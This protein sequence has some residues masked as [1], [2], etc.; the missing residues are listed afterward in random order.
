MGPLCGVK[1]LAVVDEM[2]VVATCS[3]ACGTFLV[4]N[5]GIVNFLESASFY[6][7]GDLDTIDEQ[8]RR[9]IIKTVEEM[10]MAEFLKVLSL[11]G[12]RTNENSP[13]LRVVQSELPAQL[14]FLRVRPVFDI[15]ST[16]KKRL[17]HKC[18]A[19]HTVV[20]DHQFW[21]FQKYVSSNPS[22]QQDV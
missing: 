3:D 10:L 7:S 15:I 20:L 13:S 18:D 6:T 12:E 2:D 9:D 5:K 22:V 16:Q 11:Q 19:A 8:V 17:T 4:P 21:G 14:F 1:L